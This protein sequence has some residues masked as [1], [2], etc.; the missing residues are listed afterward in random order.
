MEKQVTEL[1]GADSPYLHIYAQKKSRFEDLLHL[2]IN[3]HRPPAFPETLKAYRTIGNAGARQISKAAEGFSEYAIIHLSNRSGHYSSKSLFPTDGEKYRAPLSIGN[4]IRMGK[5]S[6]YVSGR[7]PMLLYDR[8]TGDLVLPV[9]K[10]YSSAHDI[11]KNF[12]LPYIAGT[13]QPN[14]TSFKKQ[15]IKRRIYLKELKSLKIDK[16]TQENRLSKPSLNKSSRE[17]HLLLDGSHW[18]SLYKTLFGTDA[19][20]LDAAF[21]VPHI[22]ASDISSIITLTEQHL[23][24]TNEL[25]KLMARSEEPEKS[26]SIAN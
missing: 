24:R 11:I 9:T 13:K 20:S 4:L 5:S 21:L 18:T 26:L 16:A 6:N 14:L 7:I 15:L 23:E 17:I 22:D 25:R 12:V 10:E 19:L 3:E 1:F 8:Q 2:P